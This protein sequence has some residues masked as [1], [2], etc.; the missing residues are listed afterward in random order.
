MWKINIIFSVTVYTVL[1][2]YSVYSHIVNLDNTVYVCM[3][4]EIVDIAVVY[5]ITEY[6]YTCKIIC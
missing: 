1:A 5:C 2:E 3:I 6:T 4:A